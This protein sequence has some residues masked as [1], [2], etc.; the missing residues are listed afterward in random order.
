MRQAALKTYELLGVEYVLAEFPHGQYAYQDERGI[1]GVWD[2][3]RR[4]RGGDLII[5]TQV[6]SRSGP[7]PA[8]LIG[9]SDSPDPKYRA[10][11]KVGDLAFVD[12]SPVMARVISVGIMDAALDDE[13]IRH[14]LIN[15]FNSPT[16]ALDYITERLSRTGFPAVQVITSGFLRALEL[17]TVGAA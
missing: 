14:Q 1:F 10:G 8:Q 9:V 5:P 15:T 17:D 2:A 6:D 11:L 13:A 7:A 16:D 12:M 4:T 3:R